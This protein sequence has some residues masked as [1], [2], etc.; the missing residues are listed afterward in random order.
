M[1]QI[2]ID[3]TD[4]Y[5]EWLNRGMERFFRGLRGGGVRGDCADPASGVGN[6]SMSGQLTIPTGFSAW[7]DGRTTMRFLRED[8]SAVELVLDIEAAITLNTFV[9]A[10]I[11]ERACPGYGN[12]QERRMWEADIIIAAHSNPRDHR[13][14]PAGRT[15]P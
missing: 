13:E 2:G 11:W 8:G 15:A 3:T 12:N 1:K 14:S 7:F 10:A 6:N 9:S 4:P 5:D